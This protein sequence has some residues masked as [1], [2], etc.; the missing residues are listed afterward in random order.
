MA[1]DFDAIVIGAGPGGEVAA[2]R[3]MAG[4]L[5]VALIERELIGGECGYW[6]C[7]PS[8]TLLR[9]TEARAEA[10]NAAGLSQPALDWTALRDYR[11]Y[12]IRRL[13]DTKQ[14]ADYQRQGATVIKGSARL[15]GR[16][17]W[18]IRVA[19]TDITATHVVIATGSAPIRPPIDGM[20]DLDHST[21]WTNREATNLRE[22][23]DRAVMIGGSAVGVELG[24]FL[25]RMGSHVTLIQRG[26]RLLD[27]EDPRVGEL[28]ATQ[29]G[30]DG[31]DVRVGAQAAG[32][33]RDGAEV[34]VELD[35]ATT[36][37]TDVIVLGAG[38]R[39]NTD[40]L[41]LDTVG[42]TPGQ[43]GELAVDEHCRVTGDG[44]WALG[45]VTGTALFTHVAMYQARVVA[46]NILG[47]PRRADYTAIPRVV[48][49]QPEIAAVG[50]TTDQARRRGLHTATTELDL[51]EAI[52]RPWTY[53]TNPGGTLGL[54]ADRD[55]R[56]LVGAWAVAPLAGEWIHQAALAIRA[57]IPIDILLDGIAQFPTYS[58]AYVHAAEQLSL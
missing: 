39:P 24:Q 19:D 14:V 53:E 12:M 16:D 27:R 29:L 32:A 45:D 37:R 5:R 25:A 18:R 3:L 58:E 33:C 31:I 11:D 52:A 4:G 38:R 40:S 41:G 15:A 2:S 43:R 56:V 9:P 17:P 49:A 21:V 7:I 8:K 47:T 50:L 22:I 26:P 1:V 42:V 6:A 28:V 30:S 35:D 51:P 34:V 10:A 13:D 54:L 55:R 44:L 20:D 48:F 36:A 57:H 46:D 23:P